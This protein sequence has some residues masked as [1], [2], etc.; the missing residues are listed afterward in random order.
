M[1]SFF[2]KKFRAFEIFL[3][4]PILPLGIKFFILFFFSSDN[5]LQRGELKKPKTKILHLV[6]NAE[7]SIII[8]F[9]KLSNPNFEDEYNN[10]DKLL[11]K[12]KSNFKIATSKN[13]NLY[14][15]RNIE[16]DTMRKFK[17]DKS[18]LIE[19]I[20]HNTAQYVVIN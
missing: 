18:V 6:S 16:K 19:Q 1:Q 20:F 10:F 9:I 8:D 5:F 2:S 7:Y 11:N 3:I 17:K 12:L 4:F 14:T 13:V 15:I